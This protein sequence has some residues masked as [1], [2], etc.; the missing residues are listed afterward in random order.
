MA[1]QPPVDWHVAVRGGDER[2]GQ[3]VQLWLRAQPGASKSRLVA[4]QAP[5]VDGK[6]NDELLR[7]IADLMD[8]PR[9]KVQLAAGQT[10][11]DKRV[12]VSLPRPQVL[13][14]LAPLFGA[15]FQFRGQESDP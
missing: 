7:L 14:V 12:D 8:V 1:E 5:P 6:A 9:A 15:R 4:L 13:A 11:R 2:G 3:P 10:S